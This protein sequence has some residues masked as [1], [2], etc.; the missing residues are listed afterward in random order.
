MRIISNVDGFLKAKHPELLLTM[1]NMRLFDGTEDGLDPGPKEGSHPTSYNLGDD[2]KAE[3]ES[4]MIIQTNRTL[5]RANEPC[6]RCCLCS[7]SCEGSFARRRCC[8]SKRKL[9]RPS[10][11]RRFTDL[12]DSLTTSSVGKNPES[13]FRLWVNGAAEMPDADFASE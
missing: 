2:L 8:I 5:P 10:A 11:Q 4:E 9:R 7:R 1:E 12:N 3:S 13:S 6:A